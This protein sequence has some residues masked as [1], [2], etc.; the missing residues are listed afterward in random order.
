VTDRAFIGEASKTRAFG[1][2][3]SLASS[4]ATFAGRRAARHS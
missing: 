3:I 4:L 1:C 2:I